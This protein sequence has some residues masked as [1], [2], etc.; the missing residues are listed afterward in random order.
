[1][2]KVLKGD[3]LEKLGLER[4]EEEEKERLEK[5]KDKANAPL[6]LPDALHQVPKFSRRQQEQDEVDFEDEQHG[7]DE[8]ADA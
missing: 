1:M 3:K 4:L 6:K 5:E 2:E 7:G 8:A